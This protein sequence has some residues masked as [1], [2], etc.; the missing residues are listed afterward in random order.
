MLW[1]QGTDKLFHALQGTPPSTKST[2]STRVHRVKPVKSG[3][4]VNASV[5]LPPPP[6]GTPTRDDSFQAMTHPLLNRRVAILAAD[7]FEQVE[8]EGPKRA[9]EDAGATVS[10]V[11]PNHGTIQ[12][13]N[14]LEKGDEFDVDL[15]LDHAKAEIFDA[16]MIPGGLANPDMLRSTPE[17]LEFVRA[18]FHAGKPV[19]AICHAPW[20]LIDAE[21]IRGR[22]LTSWPAIRMDIKNAGAHWVDE[23][24]VA[25]EGLVTSRQP[26][27]IPAFNKKMIEVFAAGVEVEQMEHAQ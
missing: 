4:S 1:R 2:R 9:L 13:M 7:G 17:A 5:K 16:L 20:V 18:F 26:S 22:R 14:H 10:I 27:D 25:E 8:L 21:V 3:R 15:Q 6:S 23:E 19:A 24:V 12:G 11:S